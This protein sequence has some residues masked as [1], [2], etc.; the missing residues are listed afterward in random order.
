MVNHINDCMEF[1]FPFV[2]EKITLLEPL[3]DE[4]FGSTDRMKKMIITA[5]RA[6]I[7]SITLIR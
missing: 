3:L 5:V 1:R 6:Q 4:F 2:V 7:F